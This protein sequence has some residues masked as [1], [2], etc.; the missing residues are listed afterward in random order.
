MSERKKLY[1]GKAKIVFEGPEPGLVIQHFKDDATAFNAQ[2]KG[3]IKDKGICNN[4]ISAHVMSKMNEAGFHTHF[5]KRLSDR[6]QLV[7]RVE[8]IPI[9]VI[10]RNIAA[11]SIVKRLGLKEGRILEEHG[12][13]LIE[14]CLKDDSLGDPILS[15]D[16]II[17]LKMLTSSEISNIKTW[18]MHINRFLIPLFDEVDL[19]LVDYKLEFGW[20]PETRNMILADEIS[21]DTCRLWDKETGKKLDKD[22]FRED[23][24][25]EATAYQE[26]VKRLGIKYG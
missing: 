16:H 21:P 24:G 12:R 7:K 11:G 18:M 8:I 17:V 3:T 6:D 22:R 13:P 20:L 2:K 9:E 25:E 1:E 14:F 15:E 5:V 19:K 23:L 26:V 10:A 4:L